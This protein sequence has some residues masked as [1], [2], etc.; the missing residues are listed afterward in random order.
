VIR[1]SPRPIEAY[2]DPRTGF[3]PDA[4]KFLA[5]DPLAWNLAY[6]S[7]PYESLRSPADPKFTTHVR[8]TLRTHMQSGRVMAPGESPDSHTLAAIFRMPAP[9]AVRW[10]DRNKHICR[11]T[12]LYR[13]YGDAWL[14]LV[15]CR[16]R[17]CSVDPD[18]PFAVTDVSDAVRLLARFQAR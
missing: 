12:P 7:H 4:S 13:A 18:T 15:R 2:R 8:W 5:E 14:E 10:L 9:Y 11:S 17:A 3:G 6:L 1:Y 16:E